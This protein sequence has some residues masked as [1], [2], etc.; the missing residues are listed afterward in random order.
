M[1]SLLVYYFVSAEPLERSGSLML[2]LILSL[3][4]DA[5][6]ISQDYFIPGLIAFLLAH[7]LYIL[8]YRQHRHEESENALMGLQRVR[9]AFPII[10]AATGLVIILYPV[11]G[12]LKI[13]VIIYASVLALMAI[14]ALFRYGRTSPVSFWMVFGGAVLFMLSDSILAINKF[15]ELLPNAGFWIMATYSAAQ[16]MIVKGLLLHPVKN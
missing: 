5:F 7:L 12:G 14:A 4:G 11:L 16:Y 2:A 9:L 8:A 10:L 15:L 13:P 1:A 3:A 6:L